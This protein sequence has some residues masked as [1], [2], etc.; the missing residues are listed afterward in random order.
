MQTMRNPIDPPAMTRQSP[1]DQPGR[2]GAY[3]PDVAALVLD[4]LATGRTLADICR[5]DPSLPH[6][7]QIRRW[8]VNDV[9]GFAERY[10]QALELQA[11]AWADDL[12]AIADDDSE[13]AD[14]VRARIQIETRQWLMRVRNRQTYDPPKQQ[15]TTDALDW[16]AVLQAAG[17]AA[18]PPVAQPAIAQGVTLDAEP[19]TLAEQQ[20]ADGSPSGETGRPGDFVGVP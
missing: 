19:V 16:L 12:L 2:S 9:Q 15:A 5:A 3:D 18:P 13:S 1:L 14:S 17:L 20:A 10:R 8:A 4:Q 11:D 7:Y 6:A